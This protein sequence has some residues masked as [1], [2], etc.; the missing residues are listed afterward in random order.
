MTT[1]ISGQASRSESREYC[2]VIMPYRPKKHYEA[3]FEGIRS[4]VE[5][6]VGLRCERA[7]YTP[8]PGGELLEKVHRKILGASVVVADVSE[9]RPNVY[10][11][12]GFACAHHTQPI[13]IVREGRPLPTDLAGR[14]T[15]P[16]RGTPAADPQFSERLAACVE[17]QL[18]SPLPEQRRMLGSRQPFPAY[19]LT[20]PRAP[21]QESRHWWHP[22]ERRTFGDMLGIAGI[23]TAYGNLFGTR[24]V[25]ELL[26][27]Q[28]VPDELLESPANLFCIGSPKVNPATGRLLRAVQAGLAP[29]WKLRAA[30]A[31]HDARF[32]IG[33]HPGLDEQL[34]AEPTIDKDGSV[35]D[36]GLVVR[37]PNPRDSA[38]IVLVAAGRHSIGTHAACSAVVHRDSIAALEARLS[39]AGVSLADTRQPFW[40]VVAGTL[41]S[42]GTFSEAIEIVEC[43]GYS[44]R[45]ST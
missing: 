13:L 12:Y 5:E 18:T 39:A 3:V 41:L 44:R 10:Y 2:F 1:T 35:R 15:L 29:Q 25:P 11:E 23:L 28:C 36:Y 17:M 16:Y 26:H 33:G 27:A 20:A 45:R 24:R 8:E 21:G 37:A 30:T 6:R 43:G 31:G 14:E 34:A 9:A 22:D 38:H 32:V 7:D 42:G 40:A 19:V 4:L